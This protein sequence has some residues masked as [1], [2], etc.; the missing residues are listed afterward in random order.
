MASKVMTRRLDSM[1]DA[2]YRALVDAQEKYALSPTV[3][4]GKDVVLWDRRYAIVKDLIQMDRMRHSDTSI[5]GLFEAIKHEGL[6]E[7]SMIGYA[8]WVRREYPAPKTPTLVRI[9]AIEQRSQIRRLRAQQDIDI[10]RNQA[11]ARKL[12]PALY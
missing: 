6:I 9:E 10:R 2:T 1:V 7:F 8:T 12:C 3:L 5:I 4:R 11:L